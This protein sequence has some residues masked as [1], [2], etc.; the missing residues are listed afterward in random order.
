MSEERTANPIDGLRLMLATLFMSVSSSKLNSSSRV[1]VES[2]ETNKVPYLSG[3]NSRPNAAPAIKMPTAPWMKG[4]LILQPHE[5]VDLTKPRRSSGSGAERVEK[6]EKALTEKVVGGRG[7]KAVKRIVQSIEKLKLRNKSGVET[8]QEMELPSSGLSFEDVSEGERTDF[9]GRLPWVKDGGIVIRRMKKE[10]VV[11][12]AE[13]LLDEELL[14]K[15]R[16]EA[17]N[18]MKWVKVM[19]IGVSQAVVDEINFIW[20]RNELAMVKFD[21]PLCRNM[22]RAHEILEVSAPSSFFC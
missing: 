20:R 2:L 3:Q 18:M 11:T 4:P 19:K 14:S 12:K 9:G 17:K 22:D 6:L 16:D 1:A 10:K 15:L 21:I 5:V 8:G 7:K 13:Q